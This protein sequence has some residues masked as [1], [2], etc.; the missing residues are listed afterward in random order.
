[1]AANQL[2]HLANDPARAAHLLDFLRRLQDHRHLNQLSVF[3][4]Q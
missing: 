4:F 2:Q 1:M 3:S